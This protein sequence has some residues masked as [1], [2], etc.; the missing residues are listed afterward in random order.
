MGTVFKS[1][2]RSLNRF[3]SLKVMLP[4]LAASAAARKRFAREARAAAAVVNDHVLPIYGVDQWQGIP[5][6]VSQYISGQSLQKRLNQEGPL[7]LK[8]ILRIGLQAERGLAAA[9]AQGLVHR[10]V[11]PSNILL[12]GTVERA[13]LTDFG[14]ARAV[15]DASLT[16]SGFLAGTPQYMSPE[17]SRGEAVDQR[18]DLFSLGGLLYAMAT[19]N[20]PFQAETSLGVLRLINEQDSKR[21]KEVNSKLLVWLQTLIDKL[22]AKQPEDRFQSADEVANLLEQCLAHLQQP[23]HAEIPSEL[24]PKSRWLSAG[25]FRVGIWG[26]LLATLFGGGAFAW[27]AASEP[28]DP[29]EGNWNG[30]SWG[31]ISLQRDEFD[32]LRGTFVEKDS[33]AKGTFTIEWSRI[34]QRYIGPWRNEKGAR[35]KLSLRVVSGEIRGARTARQ[36]KDDGS[37]PNLP[38]LGDFRWM[39]A[40]EAKQMTATEVAEAVYQAIYEQNIPN[41]KRHLAKQ[42]AMPSDST[43]WVSHVA[44]TISS[45]SPH[46]PKVIVESDRAVAVFNSMKSPAEMRFQEG[47][48]R[49]GE[50]CHFVI[51]LNRLNGVW[52][53]WNINLWS[54]AKVKQWQEEV[55]QRVIARQQRPK[56]RPTIHLAAPSSEAEKALAALELVFFQDKAR[57]KVPAILVGTESGTLAITSRL[58]VSAPK[59]LP[60]ATDQVFID[61]PGNSP[62]E[63][64]YFPRGSTKELFFYHTAE[65]LSDFPLGEIATLRVGD[66]VSVVQPGSRM[67]ILSDAAIVTK[68]N[69]WMYRVVSQQRNEMEEYRDLVVVDANLP[70]GTVVFKEGQLAGI[71]LCN[72]GEG[73]VESFVV[74]A[75]RIQEAV[76][77]LRDSK[78]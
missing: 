23:N 64:T 4:H 52:S 26:I 77:Q 43:G 20:P 25:M 48:D 74:P 44:K 3:V 68:Q 33:Q 50:R 76:Q 16:C 61:A 70:P 67:I 59:E 2:D 9:H 21:L 13:L 39:R 54:E 65:Q 31:N 11:K 32:N 78:P 15:D 57:R 27:Q 63:A 10:D 30:E 69:A 14:L 42:N 53:V 7:E 5:Y 49:L 36:G 24:L 22:M 56:P 62:V 35:G 8:E 46:H 51:E 6:L 75:R 71:V 37:S 66:K 41:I 45:L 72:K 12:D 19:G 38:A 34:Q 73:K 47:E 28:A 60:R 40:I 1:F 58:A 17:Q 55:I 18:S 29:I